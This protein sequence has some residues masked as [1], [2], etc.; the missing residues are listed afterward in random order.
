MTRGK[1]SMTQEE[2]RLITE[3][4]HTLHRYPDLSMQEQ[5]TMEIL[6]GFLRKH[7][8]LK[9]CEE[10]GW[11]YAVKRGVKKQG[12]N[13]GTF[14]GNDSGGIALRADMDA[15]PIPE[16]KLK[17]GGILCQGASDPS[18]ALPYASEHPGISHRCGHDGHSAVLCGTA[19][20]LERMETE[21]DVVLLFQPGEETGEGALRCLPVLERERIREI[22]AFHNLSGYPEGTLIYREGLTQPASE[23]LLFRFEGKVTHAGTPENGRNPAEAIARTALYARRTAE[24]I[25]GDS[26]VL[27]TIAGM[28]AGT[29]DF[30]LSAGDGSLSLTL[31]AEEEAVLLRLREEICRYAYRQAEENG[32]MLSVHESDRFP[33]TRNSEEGIRRVLAAAEAAGLPVIRMESVWRPSEDFGHYLKHCSGAMF[34]IGN[35]EDYPSVHTEAYDFN[36]RILERAVRMMT[37]LL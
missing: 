1:E 25:R 37:A 17:P 14:P 32:L 22:Y 33:E 28:Q 23:G 5:G 9:L 16:K 36:D 12:R 29:G 8:S 6:K 19:L 21:R 20:E 13:D 26:L 24:T 3:L 30:G 34:Y 4:R 2:L 11:F 35:G 18:C 10:D 27:C 15:L 31:R 7:T